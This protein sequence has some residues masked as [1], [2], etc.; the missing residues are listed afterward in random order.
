MPPKMNRQNAF[1]E[2]QEVFKDVLRYIIVQN[3]KEL[4][5]FL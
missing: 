4:I 3:E 5:Y 2:E 1:I